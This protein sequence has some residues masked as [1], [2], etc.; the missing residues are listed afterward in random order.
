MI[1]G[2]ELRKLILM[3]SLNFLSWNMRGINHP[4]KRAELRKCIE[5]W[6][7]HLGVVLETRLRIDGLQE[8][9]KQW[10]TRIWKVVL[11]IMV[12]WI[13]TVEFSSSG[14]LIGL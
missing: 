8:F 3:D 12:F 6:Q 5:K 2:W 4:L 11:F 9:E 7:I 10:D 14:S 13:K 1:E